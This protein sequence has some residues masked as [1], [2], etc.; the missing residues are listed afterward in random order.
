MFL[1][2]P[3]SN[4]MVDIIGNVVTSSVGGDMILLGLLFILLIAFVFVKGKVKAGPS[5]AIGSAIAFS[6]MVLTSYFEPL[7]WLL[8]IIAIL[9]L[10]KG[11]RM[12]FSSQQ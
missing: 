4:S 1:L 7:F 10:V 9:M 8:G 5:I 11:V 2:I 3:D 6:F 12:Y